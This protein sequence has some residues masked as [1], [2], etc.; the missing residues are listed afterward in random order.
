MALDPNLA[1]LAVCDVETIGRVSGVPRR[2]EIW[3]AA[4]P[5]RDRI[6]L[7]SGGR[8]RAHWVRN[9]RRDPAVRV[10]I[11]GQ[12]FAGAASEVEG[13]PDEALARRLLAAKYYGWS[14]GR[15]LSRWARTALP[16]AIDL[17]TSPAGGQA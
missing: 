7:L 4:D 13:G 3:F 6:Y 16:I 8:D 15:P 17:R 11:G 5:R 2:I 10:R 12:W 14:E 1:R 9:I